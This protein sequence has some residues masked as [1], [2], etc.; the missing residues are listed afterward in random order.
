M[1]VYWEQIP[2][3][4]VVE[5]QSPGDGAISAVVHSISSLVLDVPASSDQGSGRSGEVSALSSYKD[6][7]VMVVVEWLWGRDS[8]LQSLSLQHSQ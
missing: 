3:L 1:R 8:I 4:G 6:E 7:E 2:P 5:T